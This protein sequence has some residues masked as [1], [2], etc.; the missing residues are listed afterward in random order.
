MG[1]LATTEGV[2]YSTL[3]SLMAFDAVVAPGITQSGRYYPT[4]A[5]AM[6]AG[7]KAIAVQPGNYA[8]GFT[9]S[10]PGTRVIGLSR[11]TGIGGGAVSGGAKF[12]GKIQINTNYVRLE[13]IAVSEPGNAHGIEILAQKVNNEIVGCAVAGVPAGYSAIKILGGYGNKVLGCTLAYNEYG[14]VVNAMDAADTWKGVDLCGNYIFNC[15]RSGIYVLDFGGSDTTNDRSTL[16]SEN[17]IEACAT[18]SGA[19]IY[20]QS[21]Q[22][23][24]IIGNHLRNMGDVDT[25]GSGIYLVAPDTSPICAAMIIGNET[26]NCKGYGIGLSV[27]SANVSLLANTAHG[28]GVANFANVG[29]CPGWVTANTNLSL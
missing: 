24:R 27:A 26:I 10:S 14:I 28:S 23:S 13:N 25:T 18:T 4:V 6:S 22:A 11:W 7:R 3:N 29:S 5:D 9:V 20:V 8:S 21:T 12:G 2:D 16:I 1:L 19:G 17:T 15:T